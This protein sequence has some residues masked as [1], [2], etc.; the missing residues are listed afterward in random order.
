MSRS[1]RTLTATG[2]SCEK[3]A[4]RA[5]HQGEL[6]D[7]LLVEPLDPEPLG[8][9]Q[10]IERPAAD[11]CGDVIGARGER[12]SQRL[13]HRAVRVAVVLLPRDAE[14]G[15]FQARGHL[16]ERCE[17][18]RVGV[19]HRRPL[20]RR[21]RRPLLEREGEP[22]AGPSAAAIARTSASL[23]SKAS[24]VSEQEHD[25]EGAAGRGWHVRGREAARQVAG[26]LAG[27]GDG[28]RAGIHAQVHAAQLTR[29]ETP[30]PATPQHRSSTVTRGRCRPA[31]PGPGSRRPSGRALLPDELAGRVRR[32]SRAAP[33]RGRA[34]RASRP[35]A[36]R[37]EEAV[38]ERGHG[39]D[40]RL[41]ARRM[42]SCQ[43]Q[44]AICSITSRGAMT[45]MG[46]S[47]LAPYPVTTAG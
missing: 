8:G 39:P 15:P 16:V 4:R 29:E 30:G 28:A 40:R 34:R 37:G 46:T 38:T 24:I 3:A 9:E 36:E 21:E 13:R 43:R 17:P 10:L 47:W 27:D 45:E 42:P 35:R 33:G 25:V 2:C 11:L 12:V 7:L 19:G 26:A 5:R 41:R 22:P 44:P 23:S 6:P 20:G 18:D 31:A 32:H 14:T 1:S